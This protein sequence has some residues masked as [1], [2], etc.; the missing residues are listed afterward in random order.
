[1]SGRET[2]SRLML[3]LLFLGA[4]AAQAAPPWSGIFGG[5]AVD[6]DQHK[7]YRLSEANGPWMIMTCSFSGD[8]AEQQARDLAL[9]LRKRYKLEAFVHR[10]RF[11]L[12]D[13]PVRGLDQYGA[14]RR[15]RYRHGKDF[16]EYAVLVGNYASVDDADAQQA[17]QKL[18]FTTPECLKL[19][20][21]KRT[22]QTL[23]GWRTVQKHVQAAVGS[24]NKKKGPMGHAFVTTNP[25]LPKEYFNVRGVDEF[26]LNMNRDVEYS[27]L[28]CPGKYTVQ[29]AQFKGEVLIDQKKIRAIQDGGEMASS[30]ADAGDKAEKLTKALR[31]KGYEAYCFHDRTASSVC[32]GSFDSVGAPRNDG[33]IEINPRMHQIIEHFRAAAANVPGQAGAMVPKQLVGLLF[34]IQPI[35]VQVPR[36]SLGAAYARQTASD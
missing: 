34:D 24:E 18:K 13:V 30:L 25:M 8:G 23:A 5:K 33:K 10:V 22:H 3:A 17:L 26:V 32:V 28:K 29:V 19:E 6:A 9:E 14:P 7:E 36:Q 15:A 2:S 4:A 20:E 35:P 27:L 12:S 31:M 11:D 21:G 1:M 16:E